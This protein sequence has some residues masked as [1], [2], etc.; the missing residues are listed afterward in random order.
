M[1][2]C[3]V[4]T[5]CDVSYTK[6]GGDGG[7]AASAAPAPP[8]KPEDLAAV[9]AEALPEVSEPF[10]PFSKKE[11]LVTD[12]SFVDPCILEVIHTS[13]GYDGG[14]P[15]PASAEL[16]KNLASHTAICWRNK[17]TTDEGIAKIEALVKARYEN[18]VIAR[19]G[20]TVTLDMG[21][22]PGHVSH[23]RTGWSIHGSPVLDAMS[24]WTALEAIRVFKMAMAREPTATRYV[25]N[26]VVVTRDLRRVTYDK[27][28]D[29]IQVQ[30]PSYHGGI[31]VAEP[32]HGDVGS[33]TT[34]DRNKLPQRTSEW[35]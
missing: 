21:L 31:W 17:L 33:V 30:D 16:R 6:P 9:R 15:P 24:D 26:F 29:A 7:P 25:A 32:L 3:L 27:K 2:G 23:G 10:W 35:H 12:A 4:G 5:A 34:L 13:Y 11:Y 19:N 18:P 22:V 8:P 1:F 14:I 20:D 28:Y